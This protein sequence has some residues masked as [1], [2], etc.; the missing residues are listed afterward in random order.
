MNFL[1]KGKVTNNG[2]HLMLYQVEP[3]LS[4]SFIRD[5]KRVF[6]LRV[7]QILLSQM[8]RETYGKE[9]LVHVILLPG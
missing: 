6:M 3:I 9:L 1:E 2:S 4:V 7:T 8:H 5:I